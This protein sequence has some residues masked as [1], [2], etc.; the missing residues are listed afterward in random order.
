[1]GHLPL[2][3]TGGMLEA[4][5]GYPQARRLLVHINNTN[6]IL[7]AG[8]EESRLLARHGIEVAYDGQVIDI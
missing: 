5:S 1:M 2:A 4:L 6:P 3:G 8:G 7:D